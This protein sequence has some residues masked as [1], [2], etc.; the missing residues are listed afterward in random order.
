MFNLKAVSSLEKI[1]QD[2]VCTEKAID[3]VCALVGEK[4][5]FQFAYHTDKMG[6][7]RFEITADEGVEYEAFFVGQ[8]PVNF[9]CYPNYR[10]HDGYI[11]HN[12]AVLP[13]PLYPVDR[14]WVQAN[15]LW[16][17][18]W[19]RASAPAGEHK[20]TITFSTEE[21]EIEATSTV[22]IKVVDAVLPE[23]TTKF[24]QWFH[25][26][27]ISAY[28][29]LESF[30][31]EHW[32]MTERFIKMA[33]DGGIN[34]L[35]TPFFTPPLDTLVGGERPTTQLTIIKKDGDKY[36]FDFSRAHRWIEY[37]KSVGIKYIEFPHLF[38]QWG[39]KFCPKIVAEVNGRTERIFGWDVSA[40]DP[41]YDNFLAQFLPAVKEFLKSEGML[42]NT[43][44]HISDE[45]SSKHLE[46]YVAARKVAMKYLEGCNTMDALSHIEYY[47]QGLVDLPVPA[48]SRIERW[49]PADTLKERWCYY[50]CGAAE[51]NSNRYITMPSSRTRSIG[52][53]MYKYKMDGFLHWGFNFYFSE[54][55]RIMIDP[56]N[57]TDGYG[58]FPSG[59]AYS[60]YPAKDG[61]IPALRLF[62]FYD[63]LQDIRALQLLEKYIGHDKTVELI[64]GV[65]GNITFDRCF[66]ADEL[67]KMRELVNAKIAE[68]AK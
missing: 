15:F 49:L 54:H 38:T 62:V 36:E 12:A 44:F 42:E 60:V 55:S 33:A 2:Y 31:E 46:A 25:T 45:P 14:D 48:L 30:S 3:S 39:A 40:T 41:S 57:V 24:T 66:E 37:A 47:E 28:Y 11:T 52:P 26:D 13:D 29:G 16:Q 7:R 50:C 63:A 9:P 10:A 5:S 6:V 19:I 35:L 18:I 67:I 53:Q 43:V 68:L 32:S 8:V 34:M 22:S 27:C 64:E 58:A 20:L 23:Q 4:V 59:D 21:G 61:P 65:L 1:R 51:G 56:F 17:S